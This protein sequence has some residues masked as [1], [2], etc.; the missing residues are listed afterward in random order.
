V[1]RAEFQDPLASS[2]FVEYLCYK[3]CFEPVCKVTIDLTEKGIERCEE[4]VELFF[5]Y[6]A[7]LRLQPWQ[8]W[9]FDGM[10]A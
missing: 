4:I 5:Q 8:Q 10:S 2:K 9:I 7:M 3:P 6:L 1:T